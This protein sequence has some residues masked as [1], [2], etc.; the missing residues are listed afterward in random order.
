MENALDGI[1]VIVTGAAGGIGSAT[2]LRLAESGAQ[3]F[4]TDISGEWPEALWKA[5]GVVGKATGDLTKETDVEEIFSRAIAA[6]GSV[7]GLV[8]NAG[9]TE[10]LGRTANQSL[11]DWRQTVDVNLLSTYLASRQ[12][13][14]VMRGGAIVNVSSVAG[15]C[16][17]PASN[18]Y[19]VS[20]AGVV[21]MTKTMAL[22]L[23]RMN[24]RVNAV[25]PGV[26]DA[27]M[28][29]TVMPTA[30][31]RTAMERRIPMG[32]FGSAEEVADVI[33]F[34]MSPAA[35][36][37][38]GAIVPVDGGWSAFGG[39]GNASNDYGEET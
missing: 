15:L 36:Y 10:T 29:Y 35:R 7:E 38:T 11:A 1:R 21:M 20:K 31:A 9:A 13:T 19:S 8:N 6:M 17:F 3:V 18:A 16:A 24:I 25:A 34:L 14:R 26:I 30:V 37:V 12:A 23:A 22:D 33:R 2:A 39:A 27:P 28:A 5:D 32:R 4:V